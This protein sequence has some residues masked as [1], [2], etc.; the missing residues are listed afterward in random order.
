ML[1]F[2]KKTNSDQVRLVDLKRI[3]INDENLSDICRDIFD[4]S[5]T[6]ENSGFLCDKQYQ[7]L[8]ENN[9]D[10]KPN[11]YL[12]KLNNPSLKSNSLLQKITKLEAALEDCNYEIIALSI[13]LEE[14]EL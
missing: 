6:G 2:D 9:W 13:E 11:K 7:V 12:E 5:N 10:L 1:Y 8:E 14:A 4:D 3:K